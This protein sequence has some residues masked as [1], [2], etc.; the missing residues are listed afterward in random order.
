MRDIDKI[1]GDVL[2]VALRIHRDLGPG[3]LESVYEIV[4]AGRLAAMGYAVE[5]QRAESIEFEGINFDAAFRVDLLVDERLVVEIK[6]IERLSA[7]H[8]KQLLTYLR[9]MK[10]PVG[11]LLNFGGDTLKEGVRRIVNDYRPSA[12]PRLRVN[13]NKGEG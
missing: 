6:S 2:D 8:G 7:V 12:S 11:L 4:L 13:E 5:R 9:L 3:L 1:S 10:Q